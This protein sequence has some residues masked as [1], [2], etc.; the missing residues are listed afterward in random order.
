[1]AGP[2]LRPG[3][4][5]C[6]VSYSTARSSHEPGHASAA[7]WSGEVVSAPLHVKVIPEVVRKEIILVPT[8]LTEDADGQIRFHSLDSE[9]LEINVA[10]GLKVCTSIESP[11][12]GSHLTDSPPADPDTVDDFGPIADVSR[13]PA[14]KTLTYT[15]DVFTTTELRRNSQ[16]GPRTSIWKKTLSVVT[17][18]PRPIATSPWSPAARGLQVRAQ[19]PGEV[20]QNAEIPVTLELKCEPG[21]LPNGIS[22]FDTGSSSTRYQLR[23]VNRA[24]GKEYTIEPYDYGGPQPMFD[25]GRYFDPLDGTPLHP[26]MLRFELLAAAPDL[27]TGDYQCTVSYSDIRKKDERPRS[28][29][30]TFWSGELVSA[31]VHIEVIPKTS[32]TEKILVPTRLFV[33]SDGM[34]RMHS[35]YSQPVNVTVESGMSIETVVAGNGNGDEFM[36]G[37]GPPDMRLDSQITMAN[38]MPSG[39][40]VQL[41]IEVVETGPY[42]DKSFWGDPHWIVWKKTFSVAIPK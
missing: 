6:T 10:N 11:E 37:G 41:T 32:R 36:V 29:E 5:V 27:P 40:K 35:E 16:T 26:L 21:L 19:I 13:L 18:N 9:P 23:M 12:G 2:E 4:Y 25:D 8:R 1:L 22:R 3:D 42:P 28:N 34:I 38:Q 31:P 20:E 17:V 24:S 33:D 7:S 30:V 14:G 39:K 15:I